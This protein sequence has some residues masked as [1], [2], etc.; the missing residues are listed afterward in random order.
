MRCTLPVMSIAVPLE[1]LPGAVAARPFGYLLTAGDERPHAVALRP[2]V[3]DDGGLRFEAGGR[4]CGNA[5]ARPSV[6]VV[7]PPIDGDGFS[8]V[9]DGDAMV[10]GDVVVVT[11]T[12]AVRHRPAP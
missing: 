10:K 2:V 1:D 3:Q 7:F 6:S 8:L 9:V 11:P 5:I 4:T 12:W